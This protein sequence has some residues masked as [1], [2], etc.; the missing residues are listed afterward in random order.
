MSSDAVYWAQQ[1]GGLEFEIVVLRRKLQAEVEAHA[2]TMATYNALLATRIAA[3]AV[4]RE[5]PGKAPGCPVVTR[6]PVEATGMG[7]DPNP[8]NCGDSCADPD[9]PLHGAAVRWGLSDA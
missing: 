4:E 5:S 8:A 7:S 2:A 1:A 9:C 3:A 6:K